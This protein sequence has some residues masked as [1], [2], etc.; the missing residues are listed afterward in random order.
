MVSVSGLIDGEPADLDVGDVAGPDNPLGL[1]IDAR[2]A[3]T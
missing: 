3:A 1:L 2:L